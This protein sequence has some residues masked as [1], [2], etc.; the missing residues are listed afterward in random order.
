[1]PFAR[2]TLQ[3]LA[4][5]A[6]IGMVLASAGLA[7]EAGEDASVEVLRST[8]AGI[9]NAQTLASSELRDWEARK[10]VMAELLEVHRQEI[11]LLGE[12]LEKSGRSAPGHDEAV[13]DAM[14]EIAALRAARANLTAAI[15][16]ARPRLLAISGRFPQPL[17]NDAREDLTQLAAWQPGDEPREALQ[18]LL[19]VLSK[20]AQFNRRISR[21]LEVIEDR[22][23]EVLYLGL[24]RAFYAD[25]SGNSGIG[26]PTA[27][28]WQWRP[29]PKINR[30]ILHAL[31]ILDQKRPP[32]RVE[33]PLQIK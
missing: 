4:I 20:A 26:L 6:A 29:D 1:M 30:Q 13:S 25:R 12:E 10:A 8:I 2:Q 14:S 31:D 33:L 17:A 19:G 7:D 24:A 16:R 32:T 5:A 21:S 3:P 15:E 18:A 11:A 23:A 28:G 9:V 22:E 27:D